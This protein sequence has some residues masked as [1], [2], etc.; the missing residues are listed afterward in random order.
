MKKLS[1]LLVLLFSQFLPFISYGVNSVEDTIIEI[2][3]GDTLKLQNLGKARLIGID[4]PE[5]RHPHKPIELFAFE[6]RDCLIK[7]ARYKKVKVIYDSVNNQDR[8]GRELVYLF[9]E[10]GTFLNEFMISEGCAR[11]YLKYPFSK[12]NQKIFIEAEK[13]AKSLKRGMWNKLNYQYPYDV[14]NINGVMSLIPFGEWNKDF[15][16]ESDDAVAIPKNY[17]EDLTSD[18]Q[19]MTLSRLV[20]KMEFDCSQ[21]KKCT[22]MISCEE[23]LYHLNECRYT[24]LDRDKDGIPCENICGKSL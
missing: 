13:K 12:K 9:L 19:V 16:I 14:K 1:I 18:K 2:I 24:R 3:D 17:K 6:S 10:D 22:E 15:E 21:R 23:A 20:S 11:A 5:S 7:A 4:A 8:Y